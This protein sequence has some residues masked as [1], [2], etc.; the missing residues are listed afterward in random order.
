MYV[1]PGTR[2]DDYEH[3][4]ALPTDFPAGDIDNAYL[5]IPAPRSDRHMFDDRQGFYLAA[6][7]S[8]RRLLNRSK[9]TRKRMRL[10]TCS[11]RRLY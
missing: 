6:E 4:V 7:I 3:V 1:N 8:I 5:S 11:D 10:M 2:L 9:E